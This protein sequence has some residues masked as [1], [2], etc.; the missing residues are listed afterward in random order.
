MTEHYEVSSS[1]MSLGGEVDEK[2]NTCGLGCLSIMATAKI[3]YFAIKVGAVFAV[4][5]STVAESTPHLVL[6]TKSGGHSS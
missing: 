5:F 4:I 1:P 2:P 6:C 3:T